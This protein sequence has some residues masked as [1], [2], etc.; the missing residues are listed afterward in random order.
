M[1]D[2][3]FSFIFIGLL[4][5]LSCAEMAASGATVLVQNG[6]PHATIVIAN[7]ATENARIGAEEFQRY[8][9]KM[10]GARLPILTDAQQ[11]PSQEPLVLIG[12][13]ALTEKMPSLS[14]C[15]STPSEG[16]FSVKAL[17]P[18]HT[19]EG[20]CEGICCAS[21][22]I[23]R[24]FPPHLLDIALE[25]FCADTVPVTLF[26][27][28]MVA[29]GFRSGQAPSLRMPP[30]RRRKSTKPIKIKLKT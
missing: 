24:P 6:K 27:M 23:W 4:F 15:D 16:I 13:S 7:N 22:G 21:V 17:R 5:A 20:P 19:D 14:S 8:I 30:S 11:I 18:M 29:C 25:F 12:R 26:A 3:V 1:L 2:H 10:S 28:T 9:E